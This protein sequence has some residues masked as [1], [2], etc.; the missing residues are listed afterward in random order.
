MLANVCLAT[1]FGPWQWRSTAAFHYRLKS[2]SN[3]IFRSFYELRIWTSHFVHK[4]LRVMN[5]VAN[6]HHDSLEIC[7]IRFILILKY[8]LHPVSVSAPKVRNP[9]T[10]GHCDRPWNI[11]SQKR[12]N[13]KYCRRYSLSF[14]FE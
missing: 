12:N 3:K 7:N 13:L 14:Y 8:I 1:I 11:L 2:T 10:R 5:D 4:E 6:F 9:T